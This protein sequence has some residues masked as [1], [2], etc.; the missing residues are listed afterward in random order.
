[1]RG[2]QEVGKI[3]KERQAGRE[4]RQRQAGGWGKREMDDRTM[5]GKRRR[6][7]EGVGRSGSLYG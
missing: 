1:M 4:N 6:Q 5:I 3:G 2:R 7:K